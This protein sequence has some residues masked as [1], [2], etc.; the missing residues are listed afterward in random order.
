MWYARN[1]E[2]KS[3]KY[4]CNFFSLHTMNKKQWIFCAHHIIDFKLEEPYCP[5]E[6]VKLLQL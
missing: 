2:D 6:N 5:L 3:F 4:V 1:N